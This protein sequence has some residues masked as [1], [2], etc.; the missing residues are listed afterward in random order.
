[1]NVPPSLVPA[2][3]HSPTRRRL[4]GTCLLAATGLAV[5]A[6]SAAAPQASA[7]VGDLTC[8]GSSA[9]TYK[10][11]LKLDTGGPA[12]TKPTTLGIKSTM[13]TC[14]SLKDRS[15]NNG[16]VRGQA[17]GTLNCLLAGKLDGTLT[18]T[19]NNK[20]SS[21][22]KFSGALDARPYGQVVAVLKG[23]VISGEFK[24]DTVVIQVLLT[25]FNAGTCNSPKGMTDT[26]GPTTFTA[27]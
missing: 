27:A 15:I 13:G 11:G 18:I 26:G 9:I 25:D 1:M 4:R 2:M 7:G 19:Y 16:Q 17:K 6:L 22:V 10:P 24:D 5:A 23:S 21:T 8:T 3:R 14:A 12:D 20:K